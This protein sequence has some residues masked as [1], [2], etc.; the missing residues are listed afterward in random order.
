MDIASDDK[1]LFDDLC[2]ILSERYG[3]VPPLGGTP[4]LIIKP[5]KFSWEIAQRSLGTFQSESEDRQLG[6]AI[7]HFVEALVT[8]KEPHAD[9][10][11]LNA[12]NRRWVMERNRNSPSMVA[13]K[14]DET[15][16]ALKDNI[17]L[18]EN[19]KW[20]IGF[21]SL[22]DWLHSL[23]LLSFKPLDIAHHFLQ[24]G[25]PF[26][27][28]AQLSNPLN[29]RPDSS[30]LRLIPRPQSHNVE[31]KV[32]KK[33]P[34]KFT[35]D[36]YREYE[37]R[38]AHILSEPYGRAALLKGGIVWRIAREV[39]RDGDALA[40]PSV[41]LTQDGFGSSIRSLDNSIWGDDSLSHVELE[42]ITGRYDCSLGKC[43]VGKFSETPLTNIIEQPLDK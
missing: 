10:W 14:L 26:R 39:I 16:I 8:G 17:I 7:L 13:Y 32:G 30:S 23:R 21:S 4:S 40:G 3:F 15:F 1:P 25:I 22:E 12:G 9:V 6:D 11:D 29:E 38:R 5:S 42:I 19:C 27:T 41:T 36:D 24:R 31:H 33:T 34:Y 2:V 43:I 18:G 37:H 20:I 28:F 35:V